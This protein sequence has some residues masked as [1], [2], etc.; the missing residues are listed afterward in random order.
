LHCA[1]RKGEKKVIEMLLARD[2][3][4]VNAENCSGLTPLELAT[5]KREMDVI[6]M[7]EAKSAS[8]CVI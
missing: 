7:L 6:E 2:D 4:V 3:V 1:V 8:Q 5:R